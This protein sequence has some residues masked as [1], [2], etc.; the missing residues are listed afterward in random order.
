MDAGATRATCGALAHETMSK[1]EMVKR[2]IAAKLGSK[3]RDRACGIT[4]STVKCTKSNRQWSL[5]Q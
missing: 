2:E 3:M 1:C 5:A 4:R